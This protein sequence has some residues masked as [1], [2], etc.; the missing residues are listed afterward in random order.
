VEPSHTESC[1]YPSDDGYDNNA[2]NHTHATAI[3]SRQNQASNKAIDQSV[4]QLNDQIEND[5]ELRWPPAHS[6]FCDTESAETRHRTEGRDIASADGTEDCAKHA[7]SGL[8][9]ASE[10]G[11]MRP[12]A[13]QNRICKS[14]AIGHRTEDTKRHLVRCAVH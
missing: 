1:D 6:V 4:T 8:R 13:V 3:D 12:G 2:N 11:F 5:T 9:L 7:E 10:H 14:Q